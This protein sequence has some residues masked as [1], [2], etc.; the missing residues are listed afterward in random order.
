MK[1]I[2][3]TSLLIALSSLLIVWCGFEVYY[4]TGMIGRTKKTPDGYGCVCHNPG[5]P[6][7][8][9]LVYVTGPEIV[10]VGSSNVYTL[11][12]LGGP[13][14]VGGF[15]VAVGQG[16]LQSMDTTTRMENGELTHTEPKIWG[17]ATVSWQ[18]MYIA[19]STAGYDTIYSVGNSCNNDLSPI[20]D[21]FN[22]G[23][24]FYINVIDTLKI[25][26][27]DGEFVGVQRGLTYDVAY[28]TFKG[29][30]II[31]P[32]NGIEYT[33]MDVGVDI[34]GNNSTDIFVEMLLPDTLWSQ[35]GT[36]LT[37][38]FPSAGASSG[39]RIENGELFNP[40]I[41][42]SFTLNDTG[43]CKLRLGFV[44]TIPWT[45]I[46]STDVYQGRITSTVYYND[47]NSEITHRFTTVMMMS[48]VVDAIKLLLIE[49]DGGV[50]GTISNVF[51]S[52]EYDTSAETRIIYPNINGEIVTGDIG[53]DIIGDTNSNII[54]E[55]DFPT[56]IIDTN[57][58]SISITFP[59]QG[60]ASGYWVESNQ[61]FNPNIGNAFSLGGNGTCKLRF[62]YEFLIPSNA[63]KG[64]TY[65]GQ[66]L[67]NGYYSSPNFQLNQM[68]SAV[69]TIHV[70]IKDS[71]LSVTE[72]NLPNKIELLQ[73][74]PNPF[75]PL[76]N[77]GF[78]IANFGLVTLKIYDVLGREV[79]TLD[80]EVKE[81]GEHFLQWNASGFPSG[82]YYYRLM[83]T[84][85]AGLSGEFILVRKLLFLK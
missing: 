40:N 53:V 78:R 46:R 2:Q 74:F 66:I 59:S 16:S 33:S 10:S 9:I 52:V 5:V 71:T 18:F 61:L 24:D 77:F 56:H 70:R 49:K 79:A 37:I 21:E 7:D 13:S 27:Q 45:P 81:A 55:T 14:V 11:H 34:F 43:S 76:T 22:Y 15:N 58:D 3:S 36:P 25:I 23:V 57:G 42:N 73:N 26:S 62:G 51:Y 50:E 12:I 35:N 82:V 60:V 39:I 4:S 1:K 67:C 54:F 30:T 31:T 8:T 32:D 69:I 20:G 84:P 63:T 65:I 80:N 29:T 72:E 48:V 44:V 38:S 68:T 28:D 47:G 64:D 6:T 83:V 41:K 85:T 75:N 17:D 19:P